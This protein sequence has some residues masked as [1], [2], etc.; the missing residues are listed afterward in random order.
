MSKT[1]NS[2]PNSGKKYTP[3]AEKKIIQEGKA[4]V[5]VKETAKD[6]GRTPVAIEDKRHRLLN[7]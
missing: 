7:K 4:H 6:L 2:A 3:P 1:N 5:P